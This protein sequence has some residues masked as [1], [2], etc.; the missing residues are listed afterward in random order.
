[1]GSTLRRVVTISAY[2]FQISSYFEL[3]VSRIQ[4]GQVGLKKVFLV[5][6]E[7]RWKVF[8][9]RVMAP[10]RR[11]EQT[12]LVSRSRRLS[13]QTHKE[14]SKI[15]SDWRR[16]W[17]SASVLVSPPSSSSS[18]SPSELLSMPLSFVPRSRQKVQ[19]LV[20]NWILQIYTSMTSVSNPRLTNPSFAFRSLKAK[21]AH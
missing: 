14:L 7:L 16:L 21:V 13:A 2:K 8:E 3:D 17:V 18:S 12:R 11:I 5:N 15:N 9:S 19:E 6:R 1:M 20:G 4:L 10:P